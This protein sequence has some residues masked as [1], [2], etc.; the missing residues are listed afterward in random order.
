MHCWVFVAHICWRKYY[1]LKDP[2]KGEW[3]P[4]SMRTEGG[5]LAGHFVITGFLSPTYLK[6]NSRISVKE[7]VYLNFYPLSKSQLSMGINTCWTTLICV[8]IFILFYFYF[9]PSS[10]CCDFSLIDISTCYGF[11]SEIFMVLTFFPFTS[12]GCC[13]QIYKC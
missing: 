1:S 12:T 7:V 6:N 3:V 11:K 2:S 10:L 5:P 13:I 4:S 9:F 8:S